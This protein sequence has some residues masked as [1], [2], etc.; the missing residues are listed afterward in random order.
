[1]TLEYESRVNRP[2]RGLPAWMIPSPGVW[3][4]LV[5]GAVCGLLAY[6]WPTTT[7]F[8]V[9]L[10]FGA[11]IIPLADF[12]MRQLLQGRQLLIAR[13]AFVA[14]AAVSIAFEFTWSAAESFRRA[15]GTEPPAGVTD[16]MARANNAG[17][18]DVVAFIRFKATRPVL[19]KV[20][21]IRGFERDA[22]AGGMER[23]L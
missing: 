4:S 5:G 21:A 19:E 1:M 10:G 13:T 7:I 17:P 20:L 18:G 6:F 11:L 3:M 2:R 14:V 15:F 12:P 16:L 9:P 23:N 22:D 8:C